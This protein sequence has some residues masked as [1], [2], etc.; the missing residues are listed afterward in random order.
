[1]H[2]WTFRA[3]NAFLPAGL[4]E[5]PA[6][7]SHGRMAMEIQAHLAAGVD[8]FFCDFPDLARS[9]LDGKAR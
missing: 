5:G 9:A 3:E 8:G 6:P 1:V 4:R 2:A 7:A